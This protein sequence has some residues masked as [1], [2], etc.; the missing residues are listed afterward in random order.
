MPP[1]SRA[2]SSTAD[3]TAQPCRTG[4]VPR[5]ASAQLISECSKPI[6][7][8]ANQSHGRTPGGGNLGHSRPNPP[9][10]PVITILRPD[11]SKTWDEYNLVM[12]LL[13]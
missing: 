11:N 7:L 1:M 12:Q 5:D 13:Q 3:C 9:C 2:Q 8:E 4:F 10:A 6:G